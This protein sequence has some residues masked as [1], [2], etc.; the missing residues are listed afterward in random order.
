MKTTLQGI[1]D[2]FTHPEEHDSTSL[3]KDVVTELIVHGKLPFVILLPDS[4][5]TKENENKNPPLAISH[6]NFCAELRFLKKINQDQSNWGMTFAIEDMA[7]DRTYSIFQLRILSNNNQT[8]PL[9]TKIQKDDGSIDHVLVAELSKD[10][11]Y[12]FCEAYKGVNK[13]EK[14]WIPEITVMSLCPW[15]KMTA[16]NI[17]GK[18]IWACGTYDLRGTGIGIGN[19]LL[20]ASCLRVFVEDTPTTYMQLA[21]RYKHNG[22]YKSQCV[23]LS[24]CFEHWIFREVRQFFM[25]INVSENETENKL[26]K[27]VTPNG[28]PVYISREQALKLIIGNKNFVNTK[29]YKYYENTLKYYRDSISHAKKV[30]L[31]AVES[32]E[33]GK[34]FSGLS[35]VIATEIKLAYKKHGVSNPQQYISK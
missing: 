12:K 1:N 25:N 8:S 4:I 24:A 30:N 10:F 35:N 15:H 32:E 28:L 13:P 23:Y 18:Q 9:N 19:N 11:I 21:N 5:P 14:D 34:A 26:T 22:D 20:Q 17:D 16:N 6:G 29:E 33:M 27:R 2:T 31:T 7:G 3:P